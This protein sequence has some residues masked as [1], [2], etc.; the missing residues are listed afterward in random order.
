M[1]ATS[2]IA[3]VSAQPPSRPHT[4]NPPRANA[5]AL[6]AA[7]GA[8]P[9]IKTAS[10][11]GNLGELSVPLAVLGIVMAMILP[12][13]SFLLDILI[14]ANITIS[15]IV[16][17]VSMYISR[18]VEFSV[19]PTSLLLLTLFRLAL[20]ISSSRLILIHGNSGTRAAGQ[21]IEAFG[22]FVVG[23]NYI[24]G[25]VIFLVLIAIQYVVINHGAVRISE[26]TARFTLDALPGKQMS[27]D[28]DLN[29]GLIDEAEARTRRKN[30][31]A[32]AE[33]YG[34]MD[35][36]SRFTQRDAVA[37][38][39]ITA[40]NIIAGFLI[41]VF[42]HGMD[43]QRALSTYTVLTIGDGLVTVIPALMVS[44]SGG[45]IITRT[46]SDGK[47][48]SDVRKQV[49]SNPQPLMLSGA[50]LVAMAAFPGLPT[51]PFLA[52]GTGVGYAGYRIRKKLDAEAA[53]PDPKPPAPK[54]NLE[55]LLKVEPLAVEVGL[56]LVKLVEGAQNSPLL[57]RIAGIRKQMASD[58][59]YM[60]P[61]VRVTDNLQ[62]KANEYVV[63]LK[64]AEIGRFEL[65]QGC[66][67]AIHPGTGSNAAPPIEGIPAKEPAFGIQAFWI[68]PDKSDLARSNGF[69]VVDAV[70]VVGTHLAELVRRHAFELLSRQDTKN[71]LDRVAQ[72]NPKVVEDLVPKLLP[73]ASVQKVFQNLLR[74]R[75]SIRDSVTILEAL[76][77]AAAVTKNPILL[78]EYARQAIRRMVVKPYLNPSGELPAFFLDSQIEQTIEKS[79][80]YTEQ[81]SHLNLSPQKARE[82]LERV[83]RSAGPA[84][85]SVAIVT[86]SAARYFLR[87]IVEG[88]LPNV[89]IL[90]HNEIPAGVRVVS[91]GLIQ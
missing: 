22:N 8:A 29:T 66:N 77:E 89:S 6:P 57:K 60:V 52:L 3:P 45:L 58:L 28:S 80:E 21:V 54:E 49:F 88:S 4:A 62:L 41:G 75:V 68:K 38:I 47:V 81:T 82:I 86:S 9:K 72:E 74:E 32:E 30:L 51:I 85:S 59:G 18:P 42:Q 65:M 73:M 37:S 31:A 23:G 90:S 15:V 27:I 61:P 50:V 34:A 1:A 76:G 79:I 63:L 56:G 7:N 12:I 55:S 44:V 25:V 16:L 17:M 43:L 39:L 78:T 10:R 48:G 67:L 53:A 19:F 87:Q 11:F 83:A 5:K 64:G 33:F 26:V 69:T 2:H 24:I 20:N 84:D 46:S 13:P 36:A 91:L 70:S 35:G 71:I 40:I 14:S